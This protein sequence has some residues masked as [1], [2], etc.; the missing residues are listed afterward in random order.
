MYREACINHDY[1]DVAPIGMVARAVLAG[2]IA[3]LP[4]WRGLAQ[5]DN[6]PYAGMVR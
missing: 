4:G 5:L 6:D 1:S 2:T 3:L